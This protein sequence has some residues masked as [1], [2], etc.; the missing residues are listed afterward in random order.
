MD[1]SEENALVGK[2]VAG[3]EDAWGAFCRE[4]SADLLAVVQFRFGCGRERSEEIVQRAFVRCVRSIGTYDPARGR[5]L[6]WLRAVA[7]NEAR[8][9]LR[10]RQAGCAELPLSTISQHTLESLADAI[11]KAPLPDELLASEETRMLIREC[12]AELNT[13]YRQAL[14]RKYV[15]NW[16]VAAIAGGLELSEK[17]AESLLS[18]AREAFKRAVLARLTSSQLQGVGILK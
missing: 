2:L 17:A 16:K 12:L 4:Y 11:D 7:G 13:R 6:P 1:R 15:D 18:R 8:S 10:D 14:L 3:D 5:L 9:L